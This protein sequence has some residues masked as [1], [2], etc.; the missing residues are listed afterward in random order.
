MKIKQSKY[1]LFDKKIKVDLKL[2]VKLLLYF[3]VSLFYKL[4]LCLFCK[5]DNRK[6]KYLISVCAIFKNEAEFLIE[7]LEY[8]LMLGVDHFYL[9]NNN[10]TDNFNEILEKYINDGV[11]TLIDWPY[12]PGQLSAYK[13]WH[14]NYHD[15][16]NWVTFIDIDEFICPKYKRSFKEWISD[17]KKYPVIVMYW[18]FFCTS[19]KLEHDYSKPVIEQYF[20]CCEKPYNIGKIIYNTR[21]KIV[22]FDMGM[23][24]STSCRVKGVVVPPINVQKQFVK[25]NIHIL[26]NSNINL[27]LNHY[28]SKSY[29]TLLEKKGKGAAAFQE[30]YITDEWFWRNDSN[31]IKS[32]YTIYR[33]LLPL[34]LRLLKKDDS[35]SI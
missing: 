28:W 12:I 21:F 6:C 7:W 11:V 24:H 8:H 22:P 18:Q 15:E 20:T 33:F 35:K 2:I 31:C 34:K 5:K 3:P 23:W 29:R 17:Y 9:Y 26:R 19:G 16:S 4:W 14:E 13:H 1:L 30:T 32:E 27:L 25:W 10:S